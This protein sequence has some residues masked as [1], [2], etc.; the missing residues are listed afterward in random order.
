MLT[1]KCLGIVSPDHL[2]IHNYAHEEK[3]FNLLTL[4]NV[5]ICE[6][7][8]FPISDHLSYMCMYCF[9]GL[10]AALRDGFGFIRCAQRDMRMFF[11]F[12]EVINLVRIITST[13][14]KQFTIV[15]H[16]SVNLLTRQPATFLSR[17]L[18]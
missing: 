14:K 12:N 4:K 6:M 5:S 15:V 9:Q 13:C 7:S 1:R 16:L 8:P 11:H 18:F 17:S 2:T 3:L 10:V